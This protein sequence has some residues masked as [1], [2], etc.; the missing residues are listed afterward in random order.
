MHSRNMEWLLLKAQLYSSRRTWSRIKR[1]KEW[2]SR[3]PNW[4][5]KKMWVASF[6]LLFNQHGSSSFLT[7]LKHWF[8]VIALRI[9]LTFFNS[10]KSERMWNWYAH[11][12]RII[13][14]A[15]YKFSRTQTKGT[16]RRI[17]F[18]LDYHC[19]N[20]KCLIYYTII[21]SHYLL[22]PTIHELNMKKNR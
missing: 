6:F 2:K 10:V 18:F 21:K 17:V 15:C 8:L 16:S 5:N 13:P 22:L 14:Q 11:G 3:S 19:L 9:I 1:T 7:L 20:W 4:C 12:V